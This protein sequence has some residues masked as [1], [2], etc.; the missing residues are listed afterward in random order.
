MEALHCDIPTIS[1]NRG[2]CGFWE[3]LAAL[4]VIIPL[5]YILKTEVDLN[6]KDNRND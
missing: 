3:I 1:S 2:N 5:I 4:A 6:Q